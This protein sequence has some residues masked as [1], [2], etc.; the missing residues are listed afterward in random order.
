MD[1]WVGGWMDGWMDG[2]INGWVDGW[3]QHLALPG[4]PASLHFGLRFPGG[5]EEM[6][7]MELFLTRGS[8]P[9]PMRS[10]VISRGSVCTAL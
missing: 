3:V 4:M 1:G 8:R 9:L 6:R 5:R 10:P 7:G 2:W